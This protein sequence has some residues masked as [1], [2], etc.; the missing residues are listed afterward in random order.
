M[1]PQPYSPFQLHISG[2]PGGEL[3]KEGIFLSEATATYLYIQP[4][5]FLPC[6]PKL[7]A[8]QTVNNHFHALTP[9]TWGKV[10]P[11]LSRS[12][13]SSTRPSQARNVLKRWGR[14][15]LHGLYMMFGKRCQS[16]KSTSISNSRLEHR[17]GEVVHRVA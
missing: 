7:P 3:T 17:P 2:S 12:F 9:T 4:A 6:L 11:S 15:S 8:G 16:L 13:P 1:H 10:T 5:S 14:S